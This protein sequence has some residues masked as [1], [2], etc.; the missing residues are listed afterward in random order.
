MTS[1]SLRARTAGF[2]ALLA[3]AVAAVPAFLYNA[4]TLTAALHDA[5]FAEVRVCRHGESEHEALRNLER[6]EK[7]LDTPELPHVIVVE[8]WGMG[9]LTTRLTEAS[10]DYDWAVGSGN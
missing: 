10:R 8:A 9:E 6:H 3:V 7:S 2:D 1:T 4:Q 5:G